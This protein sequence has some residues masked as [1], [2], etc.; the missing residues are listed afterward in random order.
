LTDHDAI[1]SAIGTLLQDDP[2]PEHLDAIRAARSELIER[3]NLFSLVS[4]L[5]TT[6]PE[7]S[8]NLAAERYTVHPASEF[9]GFVRKLRRSV[10]Q[11]RW[12]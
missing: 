7:A 8:A 1:V 9:D 4:R 2:W 5:T 12:A 11:L 6:Q 3:Q 10:R